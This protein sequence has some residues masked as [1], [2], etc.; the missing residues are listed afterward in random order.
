MWQGL[1]EREDRAVHELA[2]QLAL[3]QPLLST[4][5]DLLQYRVG[6]EMMAW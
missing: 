3:P 4:P 2:K 6:M 1:E 5:F